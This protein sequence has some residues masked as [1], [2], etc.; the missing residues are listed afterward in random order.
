[1]ASYTH[2]TGEYCD[3]DWTYD[4]GPGLPASRHYPAEPAEPAEVLNVAA[5]LIGP[6]GERHPM[7]DWW[8]GHYMDADSLCLAAEESIRDARDEAADHSY[9]L[10][11]E[12]AA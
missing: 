9:Q 6:R 7:P 2:S 4:Y 12:D 11:A 3:I 8:T 10:R 1:M 5:Y